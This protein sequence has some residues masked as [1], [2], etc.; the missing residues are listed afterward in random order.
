MT[1]PVSS[2]LESPLPS[3][4]SLEKEQKDFGELLNRL[5]NAVINQVFDLQPK[6]A[7]QRMQYLVFLFLLTMFLI[8]LTHRDYSLR[9]WAAYLQSIFLYLFNPAYAATYDGNPFRD[10]I[11]FAYRAFSDP[12]TLQYVPIFLAPFFIAL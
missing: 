3:E 1:I 6:R 7:V 4:T 8:T 2:T 9:V 5:L 10:F 12:H 11:V